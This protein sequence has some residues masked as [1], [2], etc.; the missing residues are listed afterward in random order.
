MDLKLNG[1]KA[2]ITGASRRLGYATA[3]IKR[4]SKGE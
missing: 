4:F 1:K 3:V 2:L